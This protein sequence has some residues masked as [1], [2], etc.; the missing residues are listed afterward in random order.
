[1]AEES[2][3]AVFQEMVRE[4]EAALDKERERLE[5]RLAARRRAIERVGLPQV[6]SHRLRALEVDAQRVRIELDVQRSP[7]PEMTPILLVHVEGD[8]RE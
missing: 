3:R 6:R 1:M 2:C 8:R 5:H 4:H 7:L